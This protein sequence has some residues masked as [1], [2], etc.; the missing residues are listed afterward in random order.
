MDKTRIKQKLEEERARIQELIDIDERET[1]SQERDVEEL[2][3]IDQHP[4]DHGTET[5]EQEKALSILETHREELADLDLAMKKLQEGSYG[6]C[7]TC[8]KEI[9]ADRLDARPAARFC[10]EH[11]RDAERELR[12]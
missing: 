4:A 8:E 12:I 2:S 3:T 9:P 5:F 10:V 7:E 1:E 6:K 11:Q